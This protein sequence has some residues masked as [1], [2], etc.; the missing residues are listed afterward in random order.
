MCG[1]FVNYFEPEEQAV[2]FG[3][4]SILDPPGPSWNIA[5]TTTVALVRERLTAATHDAARSASALADSSGGRPVGG[6]EGVKLERE[7]RSA[8]WGLKPPWLV[9]GGGRSRVINARSETVTVKPLFSAAA[10]RRRALVPA[11]GYYEWLAGPNG[12][13]TPF[14]LHSE[15]DQ[16]LGMAALYESAS[17]TTPLD[18]EVRQPLLS[19]VIVTRSAT[20]AI[21]IIHDRMPL[22]VPSEL[23]SDWLNPKLVEPARVRELIAAMPDQQLVS[24]QVGRAVGSVRNNAPY[25]I[26]PV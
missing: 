26:S 20:D 13:R 3:V 22:I 25:L 21:G 8:E 4:T 1:R 10:R 17:P 2:F 11:A 12:P 9:N 15:D 19:A 7:L 16:P 18:G 23:W 14:F 24:R 6:M 5:P